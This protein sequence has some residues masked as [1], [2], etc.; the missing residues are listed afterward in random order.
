MSKRMMFNVLDL[1]MLLILQLTQ[2]GQ[3][4]GLTTFNEAHVRNTDHRG[5][6]SSYKLAHQM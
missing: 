6:L 4:M 3:Y 5:I 1:M 2:M